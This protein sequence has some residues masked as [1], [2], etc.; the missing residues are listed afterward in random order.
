MD[1]L[2]TCSNS[3]HAQKIVKTIKNKFRIHDLGFSDETFGLKIVRNI[4]GT[5]LSTREKEYEIIPEFEMDNSKGLST[6]LPPGINLP[7]LED[8]F[9]N[10]RIEKYRQLLGKLLCV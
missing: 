10:V 6:P 7:D 2:L 4:D 8:I 3:E 5:V 1:D 9:D